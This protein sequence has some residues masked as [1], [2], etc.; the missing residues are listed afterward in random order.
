M[1]IV[2]DNVFAGDI[3]ISGRTCGSPADWRSF[4]EEGK[5][6]WAGTRLVLDEYGYG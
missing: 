5:E 3:N 1:F 4:K 2:I 6:V